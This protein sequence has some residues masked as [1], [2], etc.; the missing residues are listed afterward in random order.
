MTIDYESMLGEGISRGVRRAALLLAAA[1]LATGCASSGRGELDTGSRGGYTRIEGDSRVYGF[2][3]GT[4]RT[5]VRLALAVDPGA[6]WAALP[7]AYAAIGLKGAGV[8][9]ARG[10]VF[11]IPDRQVMPQSLAGQP[12]GRF[13]TCGSTTTGSAADTYEVRMLALTQIDSTAQGTVV[14]TRLDA[15]ARSRGVSGVPVNCSTTGRL[16]RLLADSLQARVGR[17]S[18]PR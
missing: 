18:E 12:L 11:G 5:A 2:D 1:T 6:A 17:V 9:D 14:L 4:D 13:L 10:R 16:E 8:V 15:V 7:D 3:L